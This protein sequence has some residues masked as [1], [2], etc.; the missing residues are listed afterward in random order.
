M[1]QGGSFEGGTADAGSLRNAESV[2]TAAVN[3]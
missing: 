3:A 1:Y 2:E